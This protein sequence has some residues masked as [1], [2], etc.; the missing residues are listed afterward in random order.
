M[1]NFENVITNICVTFGERFKRVNVMFLRVKLRRN[2]GKFL[3]KLYEIWK[4]L[5]LHCF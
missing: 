1:N 3:K 2:I 4:V 5:R